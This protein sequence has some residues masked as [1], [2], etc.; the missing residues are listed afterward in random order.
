MTAPAISFFEE[1]TLP[2]ADE[3]MRLKHLRHLPVVNERQHLVGIVSHR[4]LLS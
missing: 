3:I 4:D 1:Q 2:L